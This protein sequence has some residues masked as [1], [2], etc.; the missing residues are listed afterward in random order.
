SDDHG[1]FDPLWTAVIIA[2]LALAL[3]ASF[4]LV[5]TLEILKLRRARFR[6]L[7]GARGSPPLE[8]EVDEG[9][10]RELET[11]S[12]SAVDPETGEWSALDP[13]TGEFEAVEGGSEPQ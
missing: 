10:A 5:V 6:T 8:H 13:E 2:V 7:F 11:G 12:F 3:A 1:N 9:V 4:Y